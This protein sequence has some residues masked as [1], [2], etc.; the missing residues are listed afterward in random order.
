[1]LFPS[2]S[3]TQNTRPACKFH[4]WTPDPSPGSGISCVT[5]AI[6]CHRHHAPQAPHS[7]NGRTPGRLG[8]LASVLG[9]CSPSLGRLTALASSSSRGHVLRTPTTSGGRSQVQRSSPPPRSSVHGADSS[10]PHHLQQ[11][12]CAVQ[13]GQRVPVGPPNVTRN[14]WGGVRTEA[15]RRQ[16]PLSTWDHPPHATGAASR[17]PNTSA[18]CSCS[19][20]VPWVDAA[21]RS[22]AR[23]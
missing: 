18:T 8:S 23:S 13:G 4:R 3:P 14:S 5:T 15:I 22:W 6:I 11:T 9:T 7:G 12:R 16:R 21:V 10:R 19:H 17:S 1:M 2:V 20:S